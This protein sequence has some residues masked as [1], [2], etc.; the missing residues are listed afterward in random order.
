MQRRRAD[1]L[2]AIVAIMT[3]MAICYWSFRYA[4]P[5]VRTWDE[6]D[7]VL[8]LN[9]F[10]LLA[11]QPHFPGYP[12]FIVGGQLL[13]GWLGDPA[14]SLEV[15][16]ALLALSSAIPIAL[17]ARTYVGR[18]WSFAVAALIMSAPYIWLMQ[19]RPMSECAGI[20]WLWWFLWSARHALEQPRSFGRQMLA[21][22]MFGFLMGT[23][24][25]FFPFGAALLLIWGK[26][27]AMTKDRGR[28][29]RRLALS[30]LIASAFQLIWIVGL[31][32]S[33]GTIAGFWHLSIAFVKG[34][35]SEWGGGVA[36]YPLPFGERLLRLFGENLIRDVLFARSVVIAVLLTLL[37]LLLLAG[38]RLLPQVGTVGHSQSLSLSDRQAARWLLAGLGLYTAWALLGQNIEKPR[39]IAPIAGPMLL[40]LY[41]SAIRTARSLSDA[42]RTSG[43]RARVLSVAIVFSLASIAIV[44]L[45]HGAGLM[46]KQAE[47]RPAVYRLHDYVSKLEEPV[48]VYTWEETRVLQWLQADYDHRRIYTYDYFRATATADP[49]VRVLLTDHVLE[50]FARQ[51]PEARRHAVPLAEFESDSL[52]EPVYSVIR[53]YEWKP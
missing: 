47:Q 5:Y 11:M 30:V 41:A 12:Y 46:R 27:Y 16:N 25:S 35:F 17:L 20:A 36:S 3:M 50:G 45:A 6:V 8:A 10:D 53:L 32:L 52:F 26:Q 9:R 37:V 28:R 7:F 44:Q 49:G 2:T 43:W 34:H 13:L 22:A 51:N 24:L 33:E 18:R 1:I 29:V 21:S 23:R 4:S 14:R 39:H 38:K 19:G 15:L 40:L 31:A 48:I 42:R